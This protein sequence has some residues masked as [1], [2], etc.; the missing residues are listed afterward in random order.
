MLKL[1][2]KKWVKVNDQ[3]SGTYNANKQIRFETS[4]LRSDLSDFSDA[5]IAVKGTV[6][7]HK[8][9]GVNRNKDMYSR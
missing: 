9:G 2:N 1:N 8:R 5:Y 4:M 6:T 3:S 7:V